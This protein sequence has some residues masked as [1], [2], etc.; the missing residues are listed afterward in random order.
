MVAPCVLVV[1]DNGVNV[2]L[3]CFV[4]TAAGFEVRGAADAAEAQR[5]IAACRPD[6]ILMD[7]QMPGMDGL[8]LTRLIKADPA[9]RGV[10]VVAFTAC[11]MAGDEAL[12]RAAGCDGYLSKPIDVHRFAG[13]VRALLAAAAAG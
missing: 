4:L 1:D 7:I 6:L 8:A 12:M 10:A 5:C 11:A 9:L 2:E 13:Q 3:A